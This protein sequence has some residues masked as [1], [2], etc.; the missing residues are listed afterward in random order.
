M[1][2]QLVA[3]IKRMNSNWEGLT[4]TE[5]DGESPWVAYATQ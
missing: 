2:R 3:D 5:S 4:K 1:R